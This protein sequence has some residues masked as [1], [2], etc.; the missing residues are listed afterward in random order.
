MARPL[1]LAALV[2]ACG[3]SS[4]AAA[5]DPPA[6][7]RL[8]LSDAELDERL[9][10]LE[11]RLDAA[12][13]TALAWQ[14][15]WAGVF[16]V[17]LVFNTTWAVRADDSD[18]RVRAIVDAA[19]SAIAT[20]EAWALFR[21]PLVATRGAQPMRD[22]AGD[23]RAARLQ[24]LAVGETLLMTSVQQADTRYDWSRHLVGIGTNLVGGAAILA[25]G[26]SR[27]AL[28]S[29]LIG[30]AVGEAQIWSQPWRAPNDLRDYRARFPGAPGV[31]W[32]LRPKG[33]GVELVL[34]F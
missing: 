31:G 24:R 20:A 29:T 3:I 18:D 26:D 17:G 15:G 16:T 30:I 8:D 7:P 2:L 22:V 34:R 25:L 21:D 6:M 10:F 27:D 32:E 12:R 33:R 28:Q 11:E 13:P 1:S 4:V 5:A 19:K 9:G 23:D 14:W